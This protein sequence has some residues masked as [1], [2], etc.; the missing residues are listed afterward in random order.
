VF[1]RLIIASPLLAVL[2]SFALSNRGPVRLGLWPVDVTVEV[3][4][5]LAV[6][7]VA[8][9]TFLVGGLLVWFSECQQ[10]QRARRAEHALRLLE[11]QVRELR[12]RLPAH[13]M[14]PPG[15]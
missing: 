7:G 9:F 3:P 8:G 12:A 15:A 2:V 6:L 13:A 14:L 11:Q 5:S 4:V 10:R 1:L